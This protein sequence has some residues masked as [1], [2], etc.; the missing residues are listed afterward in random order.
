MAEFSWHGI[1]SALLKNNL[2]NNQRN[3]ALG[4][5]I[6]VPGASSLIGRRHM[7]RIENCIAGCS[8]KLANILEI[9]A[10]A[11]LRAGKIIREL[12]GKPHQIR[13]KG[14]IDLVTEADISSE[15]AILAILD[16]AGLHAKILAEESQSI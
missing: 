8:P 3:E 6:M 4:V 11:A 15:N 13:Q 16:K 12:Y 9:A 2:D 1:F 5:E 7:K 14:D 10:K